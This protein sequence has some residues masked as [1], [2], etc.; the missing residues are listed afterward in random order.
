MIDL[1][2][3]D[4][5]I[6]WGA[7][8]SPNEIGGGIATSHGHSMEKLATL[9]KKENAWGKV[10]AIVDS[11]KVIHGKER[12]GI[13]VMPPDY[14]KEHIKALV[15]INSISI[16]AIKR[17]IDMLN[18]K[19][20]CAVIPY[21]FYHGTLEHPY[22]NEKAKLHANK[23]AESIKALYESSDDET[24]R[25]LDIVLQM[26]REGIDRLRDI[27]FYE[28]TGENIAYFCDPDLAPS[29][30]VTYIDVG[31]FDGD[32]LAP[33]ER[34]YNDRLK[35]YYGFEPDNNSIVKLEEYVEVCGLRDR[36]KIM[37]YALGATNGEI[38]FSVSGSTSQESEYGEVTLKQR[39]FDDL[40]EIEIIGDAMVKMDIEGAELGA[41]NGMAQFIKKEAPYLAI[42]LY[43]KESDLFD[44]ANY[45]K[46]L[47]PGY[48][49]Y[50]R[51]GWHLE[52]W[53]VPERHFN[54][55]SSL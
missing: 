4:E 1:S 18:A 33:V 41:L 28:G 6:I 24:K 42:C 7:S 25:Y 14:I 10:I 13:K 29:G 39:R 31:A 44:V 48:S 8:F 50:I 55:G 52:C 3:Y 26:R 35:K 23:Y 5:I 54:E 30:D 49:L 27:S 22:D 36:A 51:G 32:S 38:R 21:Y 17:T 2:K 43:H 16:Q 46:E 19:N 20:D 53:A 9:L 34:Y 11:N 15:I 37:P 45:I 12:L 47:H 40:S